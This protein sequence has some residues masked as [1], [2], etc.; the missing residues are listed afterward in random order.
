MKDKTNYCYNRARTYLYEAQRGIEFVMSGD[1]NRGELILNTLIRVGKAEARNEVGIKEYNEMLEK[2]NTYA[3][4]D[5]D[6]IDK[7]VRIRNC[8]RNYLNHASLK[9][10]WINCR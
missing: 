5:H 8:S 2:I 7:L 10:F 4:E 1:E 9:D 6:L 3:V